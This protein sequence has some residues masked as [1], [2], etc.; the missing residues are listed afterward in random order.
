MGTRS[1]KQCGLIV[2]RPDEQ[3]IARIAHMAFVM[4]PPVAGKQM[5]AMP[6]LQLRL[7]FIGVFQH[8]IDNGLQIIDVATLPYEPFDIA[9]K[10]RG[11]FCLQHDS[12]FS[13]AANISSALEKRARLPSE[14][15]ASP[16]AMASAVSL[17]GIS[18]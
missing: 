15:K 2:F 14:R 11:V 5:F 16:H 7:R 8:K 10:M 12:S 13:I 4:S 18:P 1:L 9:A 17:V 3:P 6:T